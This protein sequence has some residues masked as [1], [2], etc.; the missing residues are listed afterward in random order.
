MLL[1]HRT[2]EADEILRRGFRHG[3]GSYMS[4]VVLHGVWLSAVPLG[5]RGA[6][7]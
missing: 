7:S 5:H 2:D 4:D 6:C 3:E 1:Y